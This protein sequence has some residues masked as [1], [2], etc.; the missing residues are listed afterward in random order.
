M[1]DFSGTPYYMAPEVLNAKED[2][3]YD[4]KCDIWSLGLC[5]YFMLAG[6]YLY[7]KSQNKD[8]LLK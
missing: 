8:S 5:L 6:E 1:N 4:E 3:Y 2:C 7:G